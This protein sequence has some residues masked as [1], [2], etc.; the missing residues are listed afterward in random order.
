M[1][2]LLGFVSTKS[3]NTDGTFTG[4][5]YPKIDYQGNTLKVK[6][7]GFG[8]LSL[9][10]GSPS[11]YLFSINL[12]TSSG[13]NTYYYPG[14]TG[15]QPPTVPCRVPQFVTGFKVNFIGR[16]DEEVLFYDGKVI[17]DL[18]LIEG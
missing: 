15:V 6:L 3:F 13:A 7:S 17:L 4:S 5:T 8:S 9:V 2:D 12:D 11:D 10:D 14:S 1:Y 16:D 18:M